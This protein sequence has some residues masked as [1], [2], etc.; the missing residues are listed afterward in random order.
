M[1]DESGFKQYCRTS[2]IFQH[3]ESGKLDPASIIAAGMR[4][5]LLD[6]TGDLKRRNAPRIIDSLIT[7][8]ALGFR[9]GGGNVF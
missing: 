7:Q 4:L 6:F 1:G 8:Q 5:G 9:S 3:P 2:G